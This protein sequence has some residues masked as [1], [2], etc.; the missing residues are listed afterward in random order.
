MKQTAILVLGMHRSGTSALTGM[1][2]LL[3]VYL[4]SELM[5]ADFG[6]EK[7]Y[8]ENT[9]FYRINEKLFFECDSSW[10]D[11][12]YNEEKL[13]NIQNTDRLK[14]IIEKEFRYSNI[15]A[16]KDPRLAFLFP[17]YKKV[18]EDLNINIKIVIPYRN[19]LEVASSLHTRD[20]ISME[21]GMLLWSYYFLLAEVYSRGNQRVFVSFDELIKKPQ[22]SIAKISQFLNIDLNNKFSIYQ[23]DIE[24]FLEPN[25]KHHNISIDNFSDKVPHIVKEILS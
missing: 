20:G 25:L 22:E 9:E 17:I 7:G 1:L 21:K 8:F 6:N 13:E 23:K 2:S 10:D 11:I 12:F 18:L 15:F 4:G 16:I 24:I 3:D 19:P 14:K 5:E